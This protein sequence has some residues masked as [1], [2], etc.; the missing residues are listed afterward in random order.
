MQA[1]TVGV[2]GEREH[3]PYTREGLR[4]IVLVGT[5]VPRRCGI[6]TFTADLAR[7]IARW[8]SRSVKTTWATTAWRRTT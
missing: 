6:A 5:Y 3:T 2:T 1:L 7:A 8:R 4:S